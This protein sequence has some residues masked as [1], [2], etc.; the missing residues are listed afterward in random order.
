MLAGQFKLAS[1]F[2]MRPSHSAMQSSRHSSLFGTHSKQPCSRL[3]WFGKFAALLTIRAS[4]HVL[5]PFGVWCGPPQAQ[6]FL[7]PFRRAARWTSGLKFAF[8]T[9]LLRCLTALSL[10]SA[11]GRSGTLSPA[12]FCFGRL[13]AR[14]LFGQLSNERRATPNQSEV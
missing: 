10:L 13:L 4:V 12:R 8:L 6:L 14:P 7:C 1:L 2:W 3:F 9:L 11:A 5:N